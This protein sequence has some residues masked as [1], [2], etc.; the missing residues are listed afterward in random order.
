MKI[1]EGY[2]LKKTS[3]FAV[4]C[5]KNSADVPINNI[6]LT[7]TSEFLWNCI[8]EKDMTKEQLLNA[9]LDRFDI[10]TVLA[11]SNI[12]VFVKTLKENDIIE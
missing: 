6:V 2:Y 7:E 1:K 12:D 10:S 5:S 11:L 3:D 8:S 4:V 9:L